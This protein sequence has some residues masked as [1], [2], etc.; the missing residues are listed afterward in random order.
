MLGG[1]ALGSALFA[2]IR[3]PWMHAT[4][5]FIEPKASAAEIKTYATPSRELR[6]STLD[7]K[8]LKNPVLPIRK[9]DAEKLIQKWQVESYMRARQ[10]SDDTLCLPSLPRPKRWDPSMNSSTCGVSWQIQCSRRGPRTSRQRLSVAGSGNTSS[11]SARLVCSSLLRTHIH[12]ADRSL[13]WMH[14]V[15]TVPMATST[16]WQRSKNVP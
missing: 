1:V 14:P 11:I 7:K 13:M 5:D 12:V 2:A 10:A 9:A 4:K 15:S 8:K 3:H 6:S 16:Y